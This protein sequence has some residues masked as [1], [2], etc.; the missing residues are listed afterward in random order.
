MQHEKNKRY[1]LVTSLRENDSSGFGG[2]KK[3]ISIGPGEALQICR[4]EGAGRIVR[5]WITLPV[6]GRGSVLKNAVLRMFWDGEESPS[7]EAPFGDF[8][9]AA[10]GKPLR[11]VSDRL[12]ID[13][14]GYLCRF[15]MPFNDGAVIEIHNDSSETLRD[16]FYQVGYYEEPDRSDEEETFHAQYRQAYPTVEGEPF[17]ALRAE[18]S[19]CFAG[20]KLDMQNSSWWLKPPL[21]EIPLP[22]GFGLGLLEGWE[23]VTIDDEKEPSIVGTGGEDY[24]SGGFYFSRAPFCTPTHGCTMR[25]YLTGRV[26]AYRWHLDDPIFFDTSIEVAMDHGLKNSMDADVS[27]VAYWYQREPHASFPPIP[28]AQQR[29]PRRPWI[30]PTQWLICIALFSVL[31]AV[32]YLLL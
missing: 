14:G 12:V 17:V 2:V 11:L 30:N 1:R 22:R 7:V 24:F 31:V 25:S 13:G 28:S 27:S 29:R 4:L 32:V 18:G 6:I 10:F 5:L 16:L 8:F 26:S 23:S 19:G 20:L 3:N 9:G 21:R 15:E